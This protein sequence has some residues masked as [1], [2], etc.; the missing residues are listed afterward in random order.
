MSS[1]EDSGVFAL[2]Q[3]LTTGSSN[4]LSPEING[5]AARYK[6]LPSLFTTVSMSRKTGSFP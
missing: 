1:V 6:T 5:F 4:R 2:M 3:F